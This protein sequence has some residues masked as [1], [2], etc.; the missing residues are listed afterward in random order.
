MSR[1]DKIEKDAG[2]CQKQGTPNSPF[3]GSFTVII[4]GFTRQ[5][6]AGK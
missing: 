3:V 5:S 6:R 4:S 2:H 1:L